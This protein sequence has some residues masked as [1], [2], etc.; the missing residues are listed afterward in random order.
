MFTKKKG[1]LQVSVCSV[2]LSALLSYSF[3][4]MYNLVVN[5]V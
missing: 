5:I 1:K 3:K 2:H 4:I